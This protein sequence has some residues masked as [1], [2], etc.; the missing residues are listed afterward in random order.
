MT[1][2]QKCVEHLQQEIAPQQFSTWIHPLRP[3]PRHDGLVLLAPNQV[4]FDWVSVRYLPL[5]RQVYGE[6]SG[7]GAELQLRI[8]ARRGPAAARA[9]GFGAG[10]GPRPEEGRGSGASAGLNGAAP[11]PDFPRGRLNSEHTFDTFVVGKSNRYAQA[12]ALQVAENPGVDYNPLFVYGGVGLGKTHLMHA[13]GNHILAGDS[14]LNVIYLH[15]ETFV[16]AFV[17]ALRAPRH[18]KRMDDFKRFYRSADVLLMDDIQ[19]LVDKDRTQEEFFLTFDALFE[20]R[21]QIILTSDRLQAEMDLPERLKSRF[22]GGLS[23]K[24]DPPDLETRA[25]I[26]INKARCSEIDLSS[27]AAQFMAKKLRSNVRELEGALTRV[28]AQARF[29]GA[30]IDQE[31][32]CAALGDLFAAQDKLI[33]VDAIQRAVGEYYGVRVQDMLSK[34]RN[35]SV[36]RPR[37]VAMHLARELTNHSLPEIGDKFGGRDHTTVLHACRKVKE[38]MQELSPVKEDIKGD[39]DKLQRVLAGQA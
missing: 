21:R 16:A 7:G 6:V 19:F 12:V 20:A 1:E 24:V 4:I 39:V 29:R 35:R 30:A 18:R 5:M 3:E 36:A 31:L 2:W 22:A 13:V 14:G 15:T 11:A 23:V 33:T 26:L 32:I 37:Q 9:A 25:A 27:E 17:A 10:E 8:A 28:I 38:M 34:R